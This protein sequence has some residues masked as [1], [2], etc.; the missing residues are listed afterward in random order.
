MICLLIKNLNAH[1]VTEAL[2][3][4]HNN[5]HQYEN[6]PMPL[7][8]AS[9]EGGGKWSNRADDVI[10]I[11]RYV[12]HPSDWMYSLLYV[13]KVKENETGGRPTPFEEPIKLR[14]KKSNVGFTFLGNDLL[15]DTSI[16]TIDKIDF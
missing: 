4:T 1:G 5:N 10:C 3:R 14:M 11:H 8:L 2:R 13:L 9:V 15:L 7:G 16:K 6:L 12:S